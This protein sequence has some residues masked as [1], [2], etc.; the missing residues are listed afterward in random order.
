M[1]DTLWTMQD[2]ADYIRR[3]LGTV[4][5]LA[6]GGRL[7]KKIFIR[8]G[9]GTLVDPGRVRDLVNQKNLFIKAGKA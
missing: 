3:S 9:K 6:A 1:K 5:N 7:N 4:Y 8:R 2:L